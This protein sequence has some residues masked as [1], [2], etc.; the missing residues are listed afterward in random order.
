VQ[1]AL[2][3]EVLGGRERQARRDDALDGGVVC[4]RRQGGR[5]GVWVVS[6]SAR[7]ARRRRPRGMGGVRA[8]CKCG[9]AAA[10]TRPPLPLTPGIP[11]NE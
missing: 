9:R 4:G 11:K 5:E 6:R 8:V 3:R 1:L 7:S 10:A 2:V